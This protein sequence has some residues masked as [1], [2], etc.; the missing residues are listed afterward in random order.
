MRTKL[1]RND[2]CWCSSGKKYKKCHLDREKQPPVR[3]WDVD[4]HIRARNKRGKCFHVG[5]SADTVCGQPA[6]GS[7]TVPRNMLKQIAR[8]GHVYQHSAAMRDL[9]KTGGQLS[10]RLIGINEASVLPAFC[11]MHDNET[12]APLEKTPFAGTREQCFLLAYRA[13]CHEFSKKTEVLD[14]IPAMKSF[15]RGK[16]FSQQVNLQMT[17]D[18]TSVGYDVAMRDLKEHKGQLDSML[19]SRDYSEMRAYIVTF[20][21]VPEIPAPALFIRSAILSVGHRKTWEIFRSA[22]N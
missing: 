16:P 6:I 2:P 15:D 21:N 19:V 12:F 18:V 13:L 14:S 17:M 3:P 10:V 11:E 20:E 5:A 7:H 8:N 9:V 22:W 1:G 4:A